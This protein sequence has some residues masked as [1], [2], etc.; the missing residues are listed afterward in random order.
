[1]CFLCLTLI[2]NMKKRIKH[3]GVTNIHWFRTAF[4]LRGSIVSK[5]LPRVVVAGVVAFFI[6]YL[7]TQHY[8]IALPILAGI[9]PNIVIG[10]LLVFRTNTAYERYWEGRRLWGTITNVSRNLA[11]QMLVNIETATDT[12]I[13][14][15]NQ[16][17]GLIVA[18]GV[19]TKLQLRGE[20]YEDLKKEL[21]SENFTQLH[22]NDSPALEIAI[23]LE[24][25]LQTQF[26]RDIIDTIQLSN[27]KELLNVLVDSLGGCERILKTPIP[28]AYA[29]H[30]KQLLIIYSFTLPFQFVGDLGWWT[31]PI[32]MLVSFTLF[33]IE[34]IGMEIE[35]PFGKDTNDLPLDTITLGIKSHIESILP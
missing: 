28:L 19:A 12:E 13:K 31:A 20:G 35:N 22:K 29:I 17:M 24:R 15:K 1:M 21:S 11:R 9:I 4:Q 16:A 7:H 27:M 26:K 30:L 34:E 2:H 18:F 10:L 5:I 23:A 8:N 14:E 25:Y 33:G 6:S 3:I 32:V